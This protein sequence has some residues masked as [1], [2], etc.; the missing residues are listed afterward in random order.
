[1][2]TNLMQCAAYGLSTDRLTSHISNLCSNTQFNPP[3]ICGYLRQCNTNELHDTGEEKLLLVL[4][5]HI[6]TFVARGSALIGCI[7]LFIYFERTTN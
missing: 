5:F 6:F 4:D 1:M 7:Y 2:Q 3:A